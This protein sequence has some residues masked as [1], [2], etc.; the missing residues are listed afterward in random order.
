M[1]A[2]KR[3]IALRLNIPFRPAPCSYRGGVTLPAGDA[4]H[5]R[6]YFEALH[7][8]VEAAAPDFDDCIVS[9]VWVGEGI[10]GHMCDEGLAELLRAL[11]RMFAMA[12]D[13][14]IT[15]TAHPGMVSVET[16]NACKRGRVTRLAI[17][18][19]T[20]SPSEW[21]ALG[22]FIDPSAMDTTSM[23][24]GRSARETLALDFSIAIGAPGQTYAS[25]RRSIEKAIGFGASH[26]TLQMIGQDR[27][28]G[29]ASARASRNET[30]VQLLGYAT[31]FLTARGFDQYLPRLFAR[32]GASCC[33]AMME[34][35]GSDILGF[36][37]GAKTRFLGTLAENTSDL[38]VYQAYSAVPERCIAWV[39]QPSTAS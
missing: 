39:M 29:A 28:D 10:A 22:R 34:S 36:G 3:A 19:D 7:R 17:E 14:E 30:H 27:L 18:Y 25:L 38:G 23:V 37:L 33:Y 24:L 13:V 21:T 1:A 15:V 6:A 5:R 20:A 35:G 32:K 12:D 8:E 11:P 31:A 16:L 4:R 9:A 2:D 26:V